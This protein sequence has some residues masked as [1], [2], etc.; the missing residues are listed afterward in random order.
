MGL[1]FWASNAL[2]TENILKGKIWVTMDQNQKV[3]Y[4]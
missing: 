2:S 1:I 4:I 3:A